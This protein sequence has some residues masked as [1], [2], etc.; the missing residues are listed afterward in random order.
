MTTGN[1]VT[2]WL[3]HEDRKRDYSAADA[4]GELKVIF[5]SIDRNFNPDSAIEHARRVLG[6]AQD[7]DFL[8]LSGDPALCGVCIAILAD[9]LGKVKILRWDRVQ[10]N[11]A[12]MT[13]NF[14]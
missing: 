6:K 11:Y 5:S 3:V 14:D 13:L 12:P 9:L 4:Y 8:V 1:K 2:A 7:G 10:L